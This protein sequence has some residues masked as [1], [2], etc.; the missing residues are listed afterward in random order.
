MNT[1]LLLVED[2][3]VV[4]VGIREITSRLS[5]LEVV[6]E[7]T[8]SAEQIACLEH[9]EANIILLGGSLDMKALLSRL[10]LI[11][12]NKHSAKVMVLGSSFTAEAVEELANLGVLG[13]LCKND[14]LIDLLPV[15]IQTVLNDDPYLSPS[16]VRTV[17]AGSLTYG[18]DRLSHRHIRVLQL[19]AESLTPK[20]IA[21]QMS[22]S[23]SAI[24]SLLHRMRAVLGVKTT[25]QMLV[26][27][28][29]RGLLKMDEL[30]GP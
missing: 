24:Y 3:E 20:E 11:A 13:F 18:D 22:T 4:R 25:G 30:G 9:T 1:T 27:A 8:S 17:L 29:R 2:S 14:K 7:Y 5:D 6:G 23:P 26:E 10:I 15:A 16:V 19:M 12:K 21:M 28:S